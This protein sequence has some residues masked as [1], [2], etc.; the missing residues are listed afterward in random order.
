MGSR[1][2]IAEP[3]GVALKCAASHGY[4]VCP[5]GVVYER[6]ITQEGVV[7]GGVAAFLTNR[8]RCRR[9]REARERDHY[10]K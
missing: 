9:E 8:S 10:Q 6:V 1:G 4:V 7:K 5:G 2:G 3:T